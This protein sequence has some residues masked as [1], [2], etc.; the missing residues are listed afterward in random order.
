MIKSNLKPILNERKI[1]IR[2]LSRDIDHEYPTVRKLYHDEMERYPRD[3][4]DKV[5]TYL[6]IELR[7]LLIFEK[8]HSHIDD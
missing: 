4:L 3:L 5:C 7:E 6:N 2:K 1:S 8:S